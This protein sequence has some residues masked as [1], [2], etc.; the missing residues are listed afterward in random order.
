M[1]ATSDFYI[2]LQRIYQ[3]KAKSDRE[4]IKAILSKQAEDKGLMEIIFNDDEIKVFCEN[5]R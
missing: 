2:T 5:S 3:S 4:K 1:T